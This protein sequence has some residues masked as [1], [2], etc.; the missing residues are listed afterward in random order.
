MIETLKLIK[1]N[2]LLF[3]TAIIVDITFF[4][5]YGFYTARIIDKIIAHATLI[6][7]KLS[8]IMAEQPTGLLKHLFDADIKPITIKLGLLIILLFA[9]TYVIY[10]IFQGTS[11]WF[12]TKIAGKK[13]TYRDYLLGFA[14]IN[15]IWMA[16]YIIYKILDFTLSLRFVLL[17]KIIENT[18]NTGGKILFAAALL[19]GITAFFS[20]PTLKTGTLFKTPLKKS[21]PILLAGAAFYIA[22]QILLPQINKINTQAALI[23]GTALL[24]TTI[25]FIKI[26]TTKATENVHTRT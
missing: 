4:I 16:G 20:Y 13:D 3:A 2:L 9:I 24:F 12:T 22:I 26:H 19:L 8:V 21:L 6:T 23:I 5:A 15:L 10:C 11:W 17:Q 14:R 7:N 18:T 25:N 1:N